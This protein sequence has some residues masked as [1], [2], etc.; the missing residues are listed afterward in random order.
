M[1]HG[2]LAGEHDS[3]FAVV[4]ANAVCVV[5]A[6]AFCEVECVSRDLDGLC[7]LYEGVG[8][9]E[10]RPH[11]H[12]VPCAALVLVWTVSAQA[13]RLV[14]QLVQPELIEQLAQRQL[15][16]QEQPAPPALQLEQRLSTPPQFEP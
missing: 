14:S 11:A 6:L 4:L 3:G 9:N 7:G 5:R 15:Q 16:E 10:P 2:D 13:R 12:D 1:R 8:A